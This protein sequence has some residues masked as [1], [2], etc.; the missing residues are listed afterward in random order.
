[1]AK[2][3]K[4]RKQKVEQRVDYIVT[5]KHV[6]GEVRRTKAV[7]KAVLAAVHPSTTAA[8]KSALQALIKRLESAEGTLAKA[9]CP[10][11][12]QRVVG[13]KQSQ[14]NAIGKVIA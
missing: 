11:G 2:K 1:M 12:M 13:V 8:E 14:L 6:L 10:N 4:R 7:V 9:N 3:A 5:H